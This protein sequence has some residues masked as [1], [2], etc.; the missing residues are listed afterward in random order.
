MDRML[1]SEIG[2]PEKDVMYLIG[3]RTLP[4][5]ISL[6]EQGVGRGRFDTNKGV[7]D[8]TN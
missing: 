5:E 3:S 1:A 2:S 4:M 7:G 8:S 6:Q